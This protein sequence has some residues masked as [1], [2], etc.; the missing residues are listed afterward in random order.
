MGFSR[1]GALKALRI[2]VPLLISCLFF[3]Q[4]LLQSP[5]QSMASATRSDEL[6]TADRRGGQIGGAR[7]GINYKLVTMRCGPREVM[8]GVNIR[9]RDAINYMQIAC[10]T[11]SCADASC[12]WSSAHWGMSAGSPAGGDAHP[13]MMCRSNEILSGIRG[14]VL[15]FAGRAGFDY[16]ADIE[17]ECSPMKSAAVRGPSGQQ[18]Y[19]VSMS[20]ST[21]SWHHSDGGFSSAPPGP[22][23]VIENNITGAIS[24]NSRGYGATAVSVGVSAFFEGQPA[25]QAVSLYC[26]RIAP[27]AHSQSPPRIASTVKR[28]QSGASA[29][30]QS[31]LLDFGS[32]VETNSA[33]AS[34]ASKPPS[35]FTATVLAGANDFRLMTPEDSMWAN[36]D[37]AGTLGYFAGKSNALSSCHGFIGEMGVATP[38]A[39]LCGNEFVRNLPHLPP[40]APHQLGDIAIV[41]ARIAKA[42]WH[43]AIFIGCA[44]YLQR[45]GGS[46]IQVISQSYIDNF[47]S[48]EQVYYV[49]PIGLGTFTAKV[50]ALKAEI[51]ASEGTTAANQA[52]IAQIKGCF[53]N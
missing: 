25:V 37:Y 24:C 48:N 19:P 39:N 38:G 26:P 43:G 34:T 13:A 51:D 4:P 18:F 52:A 14:R 3:A 1:R 50:A 21:G 53:P 40:G 17:I 44:L 8:V 31:P 16:A 23:E 15:V 20:G 46:N 28:K 27:T 6:D 47:T 10:A 33:S 49:R 42:S 35:Q 5:A 45:S 32:T 2:L 36:H 9:R 22:R 29:T 12:T 7:M 41:Q 30:S 11:P